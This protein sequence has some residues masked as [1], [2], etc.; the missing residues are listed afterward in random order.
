M[1][2]NKEALRPFSLSSLEMHSFIYFA[3]DKLS[4][5]S[6]LMNNLQ[7]LF[8]FLN[9]IYRFIIIL[10]SINLCVFVNFMIV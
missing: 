2:I 5:Q 10:V 6:Y 4:K 8:S 3:L 1:Y 9:H 7:A